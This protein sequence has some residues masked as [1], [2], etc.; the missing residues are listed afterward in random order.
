[1][2]HARV[3]EVILVE[4]NG[5][6]TYYTLEGLEIGG[7]KGGT[8]QTPEPEIPEQK[9]KGG[10]VKS[11]TPK[12][13]RIQKAKEMEKATTLEERVKRVAEENL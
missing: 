10:V 8:H 9:E 6:Q 13:V 5:N 1:M 4:D 12:E 3:V 7:W 11:P 2:I